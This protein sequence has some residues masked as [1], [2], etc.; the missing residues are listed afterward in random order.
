MCLS[1]MHL[2][3]D[4]FLPSLPYLPSASG[5]VFRIDTLLDVSFSDHVEGE[6]IITERN[7]H[8]CD[9][10]VMTGRRK[11]RLPMALTSGSWL[12]VRE[13]YQWPPTILHW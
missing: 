12:I 3:T 1:S 8:A 9:E 11:K 7:A 13:V 4:I 6:G 10:G 2:P 5:I